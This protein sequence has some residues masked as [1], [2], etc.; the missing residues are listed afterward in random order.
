MAYFLPFI[1]PPSIRYDVVQ[2][3]RQS[4]TTCATESSTTM[5]CRSVCRWKPTSTQYTLIG[6]VCVG[7]RPT[8]RL[9]CDHRYCRLFWINV[10]KHSKWKHKNVKMW[11]GTMETCS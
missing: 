1:W 7:A 11:T 2:E 4:C 3:N 8:H 5:L 10:H 6:K 9:L